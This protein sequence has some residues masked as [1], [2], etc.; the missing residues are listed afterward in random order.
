MAELG[1]G[2][3]RKSIADGEEEE[4]GLQLLFMSS[5]E[6]RAH[7]GPYVNPQRASAHRQGLMRDQT[8][9]V[10]PRIQAALRRSP[11]L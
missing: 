5:R 2:E 9:A 8:S 7:R 10:E 11:A 6:Q 1:R 3:R 4:E